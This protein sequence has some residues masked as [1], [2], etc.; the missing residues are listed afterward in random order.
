ML[1]LIGLAALVLAAAPADKPTAVLEGTVVGPDGRP[2]AGALV[3][4]GGRDSSTPP[5][6]G[7]A[8]EKGAFR[9]VLADAAPR[10]LRV[11]AAGLASRIIDCVRDRVRPGTLLRVELVR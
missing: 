1:L 11:E 3:A 10:L 5:V 4:A 7:Q 9:L 8:D 2:Q 6:I